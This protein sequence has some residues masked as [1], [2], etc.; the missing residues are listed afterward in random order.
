M[1]GILFSIFTYQSVHSQEFGGSPTSHSIKIDFKL[2][3]ALRNKPFQSYMS[4]LLDTDLSYQYLL[5]GGKFSIGLGAK[6]SHWEV[7][8]TQFRS[9]IV[10]GQL[11]AYTPF[12]ISSFKREVSER[13][14]LELEAKIGYT[15]LITRSNRTSVAYFQNGVSFEPKFGVYLRASELTAVG[16]TINYVNTGANF[17]PSNLSIDYFPGFIESDFNKNYQYFSIG[18]GAH[19]II[20]SYKR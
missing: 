10:N 4:G 6:Y 16:L 9:I 12:L 8:S 14:F 18:L 19:L 13:V 5:A 17:L 15:T 11:T 3:T 1:L 20:P 2:P 7:I